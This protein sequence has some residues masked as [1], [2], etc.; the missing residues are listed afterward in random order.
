M[1]Q[2]LN[3]KIPHKMREGHR[4]SCYILYG[5]TFIA[6]RLQT[7]PINPNNGRLWHLPGGAALL[8]VCGKL[9]LYLISVLYVFVFF[10]IIILLTT[11]L[12][13]SFLASFSPIGVLFLKVSPFSCTSIPQDSIYFHR[14]QSVRS[15]YFLPPLRNTRH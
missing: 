12:T 2:K 10:L 5:M 11:C 6:P 15:T 13:P 9:P 14:L 3:G 8:F 4:N 7:P 1:P